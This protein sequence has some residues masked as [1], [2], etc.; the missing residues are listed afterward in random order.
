MIGRRPP[1][2]TNRVSE[3]RQQHHNMSQA[4]LAETIG[5]SRQT[6]VAIEKGHYSPSLESAF[7][8]ARVFGVSVEDVFSWEGAENRVQS[9]HPKMTYGGLR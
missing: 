9:N 4:L 5:V 6:M 3:L 8:I 1:P 2:I 7:R